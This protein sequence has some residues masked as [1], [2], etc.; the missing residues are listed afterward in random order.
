[1][2][3]RFYG[4]V[5]WYFAL[6]FLFVACATI[7]VTVAS[8][9]RFKGY[10]WYYAVT[11]KRVLFYD[12]HGDGDDVMRSVPLR[13]IKKVHLR[14]TGTNDAELVFEAKFLARHNQLTFYHVTDAAEV[15]KSVVSLLPGARQEARK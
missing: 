7:L 10:D 13:D 6:M 8:N 11:D 2:A 3:K 9:S 4:K 1:M 14:L 15:Q 12:P 5:S